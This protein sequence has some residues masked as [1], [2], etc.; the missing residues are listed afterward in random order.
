MAKKEQIRMPMGMGGLVRYGE[1]A[2]EALKIKPEYVIGFSLFL[3]FLE[4]ALKF[5]T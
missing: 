5:L 3:I 4:V 2:K 1:E